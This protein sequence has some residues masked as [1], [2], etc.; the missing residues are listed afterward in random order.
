MHHVVKKRKA[1][2]RAAQRA[3]RERKE[4]HLKDLETK[5]EDL[6]KA[7][8]SA[9]H[10]NSLLRAQVDRLQAELREYRKRLHL[11][12]SGIGRTPSLNGGGLPAY[13]T[14]NSL[15]NTNNN[16]SF[17]FP[18]FGTNQASPFGS[19]GFFSGKASTTPVAKIP[20]VLERPTIQKTQSTGEESSSGRVPLSG[21][22][23]AT[24]PG[25]GVEGLADLFSPSILSS[26]SKNSSFDYISHSPADATHIQHFGGGSNPS[27]STSPS[28]S[29]VSHRGPDS[30]CGTTPEPTSNNSP[31]KSGENSLNTISEEYTCNP[32][33][34]DEISFCEKLN[35]ACGNP[36]NPV[37]RARSQ[38]KS[39]DLPSSILKTPPADINGVDWLS[40]QNGPQLDPQVF[41][42]YR[43]TQDAGEFGGFFD[44]AFPL[45]D[46]GDYNNDQHKRSILPELDDKFD[47]DDEVV[48]GEDPSSLLNCN[49]IW[50]VKTLPLLICQFV[51]V[52]M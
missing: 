22:N 38:S 43:D 15:G 21:A 17:D 25:S 36:N 31:P 11:N 40:Q 34:G 30:S 12:G 45:P 50:S 35:M 19:N 29:S 2:N 4:K 18:R 47:D 39:R 16:F 5:V 10:E 52:C 13:L 33:P 24:P 6:Q 1:Q 28:A 27:I 37:P 14:K 9:N 49:K 48:P 51:R 3:F 32:L 41:G 7:S 42:D 23:G 8:E 44:D 26:A 46:L 20:G